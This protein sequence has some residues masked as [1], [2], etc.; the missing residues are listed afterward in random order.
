MKDHLVHVCGN[1]KP[2][3]SIVLEIK[4]RMLASIEDYLA[5]KAKKK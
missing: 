2:C 5:E 4:E 1:V 3:L